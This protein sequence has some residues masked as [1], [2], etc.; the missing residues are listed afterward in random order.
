MKKLRNLLIVIFICSLSLPLLAADN[1]STSESYQSMTTCLQTESDR[2]HLPI[3]Q[4]KTVTCHQVESMDGVNQAPLLESLV[5]LGGNFMTISADT[6]KLLRLEELIIQNSH[7][8]EISPQILSLPR[9]RYLDLTHNEIYDVRENIAKMDKLEVLILQ[10]NKILELPSTLGELKSLQVLNLADNRLLTLPDLSTLKRLR[11]LDVSDNQLIEVPNVYMLKLEKFNA[12]KNYI[13]AQQVTI[14]KNHFEIK[15]NYKIKFKKENSKIKVIGNWNY[16]QE[17]LANMIIRNDGNTLKLLRGFDDYRL[18]NLVNEQGESV[19]LSDY[20]NAQ[21]QVIKSGRV[22]GQ[23]RLSQINLNEFLTTQEQ[24]EIV[25]SLTEAD[26][27]PL[28]RSYDEHAFW[29]Q[30]FTGTAIDAEWTQY[31]QQA[32]D[33]V[34]QKQQP[35]TLNT[36]IGL[37]F[38]IPLLVMLIFIIFVK[39]ML[40]TSHA[41]LYQVKKEDK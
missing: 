26:V 41:I 6:E 29:Y 15:N 16:L 36:A 24:I 13:N 8:I 30:A 2:Q 3:S 39:R 28:M 33:A 35:F 18:I 14:N 5:I 23:I 12:D 34:F 21:N 40:D 37:L 19:S 31:F 27:I 9:L 20:L 17:D 22:R 1:Q 10:Q 11:E 7:V 38:F 25:F 4:L 32:N